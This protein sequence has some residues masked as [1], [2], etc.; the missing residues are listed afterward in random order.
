MI[1]KLVI[2]GFKGFEHIEVPRLSRINLLGGRN[3]VGKTSILEALF[4]FHDRLNPNLILRQF[5]RRGVGV[6]PFYPESMWAPIF[7][8]YDLTRRI[9]IDAT[10]DSNEEIMTI[11][12]NPDYKGAS[13]PAAPTR[14]GTKPTQI[15]TDQ[16]PI[17]SQ[18]LDI[19]YDSKKI[20]HVELLM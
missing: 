14:P 3:N 18:S 13:I 15:R 17:P 9:S 11:Y 8:D 1:T 16:K 6:I 5:A 12:F 7:F 4:M 20:A 10:I 2:D 19:V